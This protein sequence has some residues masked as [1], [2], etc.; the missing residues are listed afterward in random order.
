M[1]YTQTSMNYLN[2]LPPRI[3]QLVY[4]FD[5]RYKIAK[6]KCLQIIKEMGKVH[7]LL[8]DDDGW[9]TEA[10]R[11]IN[12]EDYYSIWPH[13]YAEIERRVTKYRGLLVDGHIRGVTTH[14]K[15]LPKSYAFRDALG[16]YSLGT[17]YDTIF[18]DGTAYKSTKKVFTVVM[19]PISIRSMWLTFVRVGV[20][21]T[22]V[23][24]CI[25]VLDPL[26]IKSIKAR[27]Q[28]RTKVFRDLGI[29]ENGIPGRDLYFE[30]IT[31]DGKDYFIENKVMTV[32]GYIRKTRS[33]SVLGHIN[34]QG[35][36]KWFGDKR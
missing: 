10:K 24:K 25:D 18:I 35:I 28:K 36:V 19:E 32:G 27:G 1:N 20:G 26:F 5:G 14:L 29:S 3:R 21:T 4:D 15:R 13:Y 7:L 33:S 22:T 17:S 12:I 6:G 8:E 34:A 31:I 30:P 11:G 2:I 9:N 23:V 16:S